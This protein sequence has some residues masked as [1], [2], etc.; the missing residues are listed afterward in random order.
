[1]D[2]KRKNN[3]G[4]SSPDR[5][6]VVSRVVNAPREIVWEAWTN[7]EH[8]ACWWGPDGFR[9]TIETMEV[10]PGGVW[11]HIMHGPDGVDYPSKSVFKDV[12]KPERISFSHGVGKSGNAEVHFEATW[13]FEALGERTNVTIRM[14]FPSAQARDRVVREYGAVDG[15]RQTLIRLENIIAGAGGRFARMREGC[16]TSNTI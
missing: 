16:G 4:H 8:I 11:A 9:T 15:A 3:D 1:M 12:V 6:I 2:A 13:T 10:R 7:P 14:V 5:E